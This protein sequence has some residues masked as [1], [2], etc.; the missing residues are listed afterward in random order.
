ML[1]LAQH[2]AADVLPDV[3]CPTTIVSA[4]RDYLTPPKVA[5]WM[6]DQIPGATCEVLDDASHFALI[7]YPDRVNEL[8]ETLLEKASR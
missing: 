8:L 3:A 5:K 4:S 2:D 7:E 6:A 1:E